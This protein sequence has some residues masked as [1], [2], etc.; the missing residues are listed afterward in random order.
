MAD[1]IDDLARRLRGRLVC[2]GDEAYDVSRR[3]YNGSIDKHPLAVV[4]CRDIDDVVAS[5]RWARDHDVV[6]AVRGGG[7]S[8]PGLGCVDDGLVIDL[9]EINA[10]TVDPTTPYGAGRRRVRDP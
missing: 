8:G 7:H 10:V 4:H 1:R 6:I 9:S 3:V 5:V 2:R